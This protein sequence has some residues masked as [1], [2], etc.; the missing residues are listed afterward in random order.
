MHLLIEQTVKEKIRQ[1]RTQMLIHSCIYYELDGNVVDDFKWQQ[2]AD[3]LRELQDNNPDECTIGYYDTEF[4]G[5]TG[6]G[7]SHLPLRHPTIMTKAKKI[8]DES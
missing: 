7:G 3:E 2:W 1:R 5:W 4:Q 8:L 6:A